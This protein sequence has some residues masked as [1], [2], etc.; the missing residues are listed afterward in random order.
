MDIN[1]YKRVREQK[2]K[3]ERNDISEG[4]HNL[5]STKLSIDHKTSVILDFSRASSSKNLNIKRQRLHQLILCV[6]FFNEQINL[7]RQIISSYNNMENNNNGKKSGN[8]YKRKKRDL[9]GNSNVNNSS[10]IN[11]NMYLKSCLVQEYEN[12]K[13]KCLIDYNA[14]MN[15]KKARLKENKE[16]VCNDN[17]FII[18]NLEESKDIYAIECNDMKQNLL[19]KEKSN[20]ILQVIKDN[21][22]EYTNMKQF[23]YLKY[24]KEFINKIE[25]PK[26]VTH[27]FKLNT[28]GIFN[29][30]PYYESSQNSKR[31]RNEEGLTSSSKS[32][33]IAKTHRKIKIADY[34]S[35]TKG[36][37]NKKSYKK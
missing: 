1:K 17:D 26:K 35:K 15:E 16:K 3:E 6:K 36:A 8:I 18:K 7:Q 29:V 11:D 12:S 27:H 4:C 25:K 30:K 5:S 14:K 37:I 32:I 28:K 9:N 21:V 34:H 13:Q 10:N 19:E 2:V 22:R 20:E 31:S 33:R 24:Y 23:L